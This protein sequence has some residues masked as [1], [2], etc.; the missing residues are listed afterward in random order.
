MDVIPVIDI[1]DGHVVHAQGG[2][3]ESYR[4]IQTPLSAT[5]APADVAA[6]LLR[7]FPFRKLYIADLDAIEGREPND[8]AIEAIAQATRGV[9]L[10]VDNGIGDAVAA[11]AWLERFAHC[12][13]IGSESQGEIETIGFLRSETRVLLSLD[14]RGDVFQ[15]PAMLL[16]DPA[17]WPARV[18]VMT[19]ERVGA[20]SGPD[21]ERVAGIV[22]RAN[23]REV[24]G[25]GGIRHSTDIDALA[26][27]GAAG[28]LVATSLHTGALTGPDL[29]QFARS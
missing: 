1:K 11:R 4:P 7:L 26:A 5:S 10:W 22:A 28:V 3:R 13:V 12:L 23:G 20:A 19:L 25:A 8:A 9:E 2:R 24:F 29:V 15:G 21:T 16:D 27:I 6:G 17:S 18:I 14:F